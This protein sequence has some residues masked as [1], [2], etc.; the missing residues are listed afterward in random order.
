MERHVLLI[1]D[2]S[3]IREIVADYCE[4]EHWQVHE[5]ENGR[6]G[7]E[8]LAT[9][10]PDLVILDI[11]LPELDGWTVCRR[12]REQSAVP[13]ILLTAKSEDDDK[14]LGFELGAD[15]YVTK[16]FS[17]KL[18]I[19]RAKMLIRRA[20]GTVGQDEHTVRFGRVRIDKRARRVAVDGVAVDLSPKEYELLLYLQRN[21]GIVVS[22]DTILDHVWGF[23]YFGDPRVVDTHI[24]K[25]RGKLGAEARHIRTV[26]RAGYKFEVER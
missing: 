13:I 16:P 24:K 3:R 14:L 5:A 18:L 9:S 26:I 8:L 12:I 10:K 22:R 1:E 17:P 11:L 25:L 21:E 4:K 7:L 15:D 6:E 20:E 2:E 19:A 23:D